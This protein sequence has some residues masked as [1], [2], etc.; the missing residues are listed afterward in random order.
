M[1]I[2]EYMSTDYDAPSEFV[3]CATL[4]LPQQ[5]NGKIVTTPTWTAHG[6]TPEAARAKL[7][8]F[9]AEQQPKSKKEKARG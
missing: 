6:P 3:A 5:R 4:I 7:E 8:A 2:I 1:Q 9:W